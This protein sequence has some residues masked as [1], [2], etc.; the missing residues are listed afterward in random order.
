MST[1]RSNRGTAKPFCV[2]GHKARR[3]DREPF[4]GYHQGQ[5]SYVPHQQAG[6][7]TTPD[8][9]LSRQ[10]RLATQGPSIHDVA[11]GA[12]SGR[13]AHGLAVIPNGHFDSHSGYL[14][15]DYSR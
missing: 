10:N 4:S 6:Y 9:M 7:M 15:A 1:L 14:R 5:R 12:T 8:R 3:N 11:D 2:I 13:P